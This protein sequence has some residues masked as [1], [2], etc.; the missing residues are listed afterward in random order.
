MCVD[1]SYEVLGPSLLS[2]S[3]GEAVLHH[4]VESALDVHHDERHDPS[5]GERF[6]DVVDEGGDQDGRGPFRQ[7]VALLPV[8]YVVVDRGPGEPSGNQSFYAFPGRRVE[9]YVAGAG[10]GKIPPVGLPHGD[11]LGFAKRIRGG[12]K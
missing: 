7:G 2:Q 8:E 11:H 4:R 1:P 3:Q 6:L 10:R 12:G 5:S 9:K